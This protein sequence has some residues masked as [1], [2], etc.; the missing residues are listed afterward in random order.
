MKVVKA[1]PSHPKAAVL[2]PEV[3]GGGGLE[4]YLLGEGPST[5]VIETRVS[6]QVG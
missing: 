4:V 1:L 2:K 3:T 5:S 6:V